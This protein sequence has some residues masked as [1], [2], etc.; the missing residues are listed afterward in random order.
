MGYLIHQIWLSKRPLTFDLDKRWDNV[1]NQMEWFKI[2]RKNA[3]IQ[4]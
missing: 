4:K 3:S 1:D 2:P